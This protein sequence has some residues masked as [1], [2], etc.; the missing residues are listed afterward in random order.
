MND[1]M[2][3]SFIP[4]LTVL[5]EV[6][7]PFIWITYDSNEVGVGPCL[8]DCMGWYESMP[9]SEGLFLKFS[10]W[11]LTL[12]YAYQDIGYSSDLGDDWDWP[13]FHARG[14]QLSYWLKD[15]VGDEYRVVYLKNPGDPSHHIDERTEILANGMLLPL[16]P[17]RS[18]FDA[19]AARART[20]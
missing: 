13:A 1:A 11:Q 18:P 4:V 16:P 12:D 15:E 14:L 2:P 17:F 7:G 9:L 5:P 6:G 19:T 10:D 8:C 20:D 3:V